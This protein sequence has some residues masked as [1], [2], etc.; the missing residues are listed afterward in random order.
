MATL[1]SPS[2]RNQAIWNGG[3]S[4]VR[5]FAVASAI[6]KNMKPRIIR[7][8]PNPVRLALGGSVVAMGALG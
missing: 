5:N 7:P 6:E 1:N 3:S 8:I 2:W 4:W